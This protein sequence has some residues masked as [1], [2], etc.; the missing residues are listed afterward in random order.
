MEA[1]FVR[2]LRIATAATILIILAV[3]TVF[4]AYADSWIGDSLELTVADADL[5]VRGTLETSQLTPGM[6]ERLGILRVKDTL[7]GNAGETVECLIPD[8][9]ERNVDNWQRGKTELLVCL[10]RSERYHV[11]GSKEPMAAEWSVRRGWGGETGIIPLDG[12]PGRRA[13][14]ADFVLL[15]KPDDILKCAAQAIDADAKTKIAREPDG[16]TPSLELGVPFHSP[17]EE[18]LHN[19][20]NGNNLVVPINEMIEAKAK[21]WIKADNAELRHNGFR[22]LAQFKSEDNIAALKGLLTDPE[23]QH[24]AQGANKPGEWRV[25]YGSIFIG[26]LVIS[27]LAYLAIGKMGKGISNSKRI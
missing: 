12:N 21:Q 1:H 23:A 3:V 8:D 15:T 22:F 25:I 10:V 2:S 4:P 24:R 7:K 18:D 19:I 6:P 26:L 20:L 27:V 5:V 9:D 16:S 11:I 14:T 17:L 13:P